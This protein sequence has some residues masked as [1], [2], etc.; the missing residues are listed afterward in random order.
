M[1]HNVEQRNIHKLHESFLVVSQLVH[2]QGEV[3]DRIHHHVELGSNYVE[4]SNIHL[5]KAVKAQ[6]KYRKKKC[7]IAFLVV[8]LLAI[9]AIIIY[10][11][12]QKQRQQH[13]AVSISPPV[14]AHLRPS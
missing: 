5:K 6:H 10:F 8:L 3:V 4:A 14:R 11:S 2:D 9:I 1:N 12:V 7:V 13:T